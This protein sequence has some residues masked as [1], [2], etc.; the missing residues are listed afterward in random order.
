MAGRG[1]PLEPVAAAFLKE[2]EFEQL[3]STFDEATEAIDTAQDFIL[4][5]LDAMLGKRNELEL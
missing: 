5:E 2:G 3:R 4:S 1:K